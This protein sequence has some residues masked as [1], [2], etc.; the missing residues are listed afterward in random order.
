MI[1]R[2][3]LVL[4]L[5]PI[6]FLFELSLDDFD[7]SLGVFKVRVQI[8]SLF[9]IADRFAPL[10]NAL[11]RFRGFFADPVKS[12][13]QVKRSLRRK[14]G[15][16]HPHGAFEFFPSRFIIA[17]LIGASSDVVKDQGIGRFVLSGFFV[18]F[19]RTGK[20]A[21]SEQFV[22]VVYRTGKRKRAQ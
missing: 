13:R 12:I 11:R 7:V 3:V 19:E 21:F 1:V 10:G 4:L 6:D 17:E 14:R 18:F 20:V 15:I 16:R 22:A 2:I 8:D 9:Q 5:L